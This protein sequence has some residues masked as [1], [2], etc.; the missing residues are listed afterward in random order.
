[1]GEDSK[2]D[3]GPPHPP[4]LIAYWVADGPL[5][6]PSTLQFA[7][8]ADA[9]PAELGAQEAIAILKP[10]KAQADKQ[11]MPA[12]REQRLL[13]SSGEQWFASWSMPALVDS[14]GF[15]GH[16]EHE[17]SVM[18]NG[19]TQRL[20][21]RPQRFHQL[22]QPTQ[23]LKVDGDVSD[24]PSLPLM[25][26][27]PYLG[28]GAASWQGPDDGWFRFAIAVT[29]GRLWLALEV[30]DDEVA[31]SE[32]VAPWHQD[33]FEWR[34]DAR[35]QPR[36]DDEEPTSDHDIILIAAAPDKAHRSPIFSPH[37]PP[38][39]STQVATAAFAKGWRAEAS[40]ELHELW[41]PES[42]DQRAQRA[43]RI[44]LC[45]NDHDPSKQEGPGQGRQM[46]WRPDWRPHPQR[47]NYPFTG[48]FILPLPP[49]G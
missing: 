45:V 47:A 2:P 29:N 32:G 9:W 44:N 8:T 41:P 33:G 22:L 17:L 3:H 49:S 46:W 37:H 1:M 28:F 31:S 21:L 35:S 27:E 13:M 18:V 14:S 43:L 30:Y 4:A 6:Q 5:D 10:S 11:T 38:P 26:R 40:V 36:P 25:V 34:I 19:Q 15:L 39:A 42:T 20:R 12:Q 24:W 23:A 7:F 48:I 16:Q